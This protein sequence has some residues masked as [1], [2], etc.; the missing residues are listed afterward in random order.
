MIASACSYPYD[1]FLIKMPDDEILSIY[2]YVNKLMNGK[3]RLNLLY[4]Q[5]PFAKIDRDVAYSRN[6]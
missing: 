5:P 6:R 2:I 3:S 1:I 4:N